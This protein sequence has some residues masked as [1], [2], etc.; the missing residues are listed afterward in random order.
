MVLTQTTISN[1]WWPACRFPNCRAEPSQN[2]EAK[3]GSKL[4]HSSICKTR[5]E[6]KPM[7]RL[8]IFML[9][10]IT[11]GV[12]VIAALVAF[13]STST[14][15]L[16]FTNTPLLRPDGN[17]EPEISIATNGTMG[18][19]GLSWLNS[20]TNLW[21]GP[22]GSAPTLQGAIDAALQ[23][24]GKRVFGGGD[25]NQVVAIRT[26]LCFLRML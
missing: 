20:G 16:D 9:F 23:Q 3:H 21:T 12:A 10:G 22:F 17:S 6:N 14:G 18:I 19:V 13:A 7:R 8:R 24:P 26:R 5:G 25:A 15:N 4:G 11:V 2:G 1:R